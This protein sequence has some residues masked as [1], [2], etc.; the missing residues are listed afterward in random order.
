MGPPALRVR[1]HD[2]HIKG[3]GHGRGTVGVMLFLFEV[4][5]TNTIAIFGIWNDNIGN[6]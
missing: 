4:S 6:Y 3:V 2:G 5:D 1:L